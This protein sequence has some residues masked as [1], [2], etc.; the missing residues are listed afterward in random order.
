MP[1]GRRVVDKGVEMDCTQ[2][3]CIFV[4]KVVLGIR[5]AMR[6]LGTR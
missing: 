1:L 4:V 5:E 6:I 2:F 3:V